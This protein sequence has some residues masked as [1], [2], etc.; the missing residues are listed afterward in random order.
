MSSW[1]SHVG[2][3]PPDEVFVILSASGT[4]STFRIPSRSLWGVLGVHVN[5]QINGG[6]GA[7]WDDVMKILRARLFFS[8]VWDTG[9][10]FIGIRT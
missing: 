9:G 7:I 4:L 10:E 5:D 2:R 6:R 8:Q 3:A 1:D